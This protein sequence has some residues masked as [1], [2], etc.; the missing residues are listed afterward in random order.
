MI[1]ARAANRAMIVFAVFSLA[2]IAA[3]CVAMAQSGVPAGS[4]LRNPMAWLVGALLASGLF[5]I[6]RP[7]A[8][9]ARLLLLLAA[10]GLAATLVFPDQDGVHRWI[11]IGPLHVN[12][13]ALLLPAAVAALALV[14]IAS[15][16]GLAAAI[17]IA[18]LLLAQPDASQMIGFALAT[19]ILFFRSPTRSV[20]AAGVA[21]ATVLAAA[22]WLRPDPLQP[23]AEVE[24]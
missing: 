11:D 8:T 16:T 5:F 7:Q 12:A 17:A 20:R 3:G 15:K 21:A 10:G 22:A 24:G 19:A 1:A 6:E 9:L 4:W 23:V 14:G 13:A 18:A 2:A